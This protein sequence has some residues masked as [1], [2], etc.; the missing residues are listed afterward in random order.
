MADPDDTGDRRYRTPMPGL[1]AG[2]IEAAVNQA[3]ALDELSVE[4][5]ER[6]E[7][8]VLELELE[9]LAITLFFS[10]AFGTVEV[11]L[12]A[13]SKP[14]TRVA[15]SPVALFSLATDSEGW[16]TP[17]SGVRIEGD[18]TLAR[19]LGK[20]FEQLDP[21]W[22]APLDSL[23]GTTLGFQVGEGLKRGAEGLREA[24]RSSLD[25][26]GRYLNEESGAL[27]PQEA[28]DD[29]STA[30]DDLRDGIDRLEHRLGRVERRRAQAGDGA[31]DEHKNPPDPQA[32]T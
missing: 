4:R 30:V 32:E 19:D 17:G 23:L 11:T 14:A 2:A 16:G 13:P 1:L 20:L 28:I 31:A 3:L 6:L 5:L 7:G 21:D 9:G 29:F 26:A 27:A 25:M 10:F 12:T 8:K 22:Q 18:A 24:L 15:G